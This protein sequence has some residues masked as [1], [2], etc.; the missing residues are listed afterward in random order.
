MADVRRPCVPWNEH[1]PTLSH[2]HTQTYTQTHTQTRCGVPNM[3]F[4]FSTWKRSTWNSICHRLFLF[5]RIHQSED[6]NPC[7]GNA[8]QPEICA[9]RTRNL[10]IGNR[11]GDVGDTQRAHDW[12]FN[13]VIDGCFDIFHLH[14]YVCLQ[15]T[16]QLFSIFKLLH[17]HPLSTLWV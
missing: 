15:P 9:F 5:Y 4:N 10:L 6:V 1:A 3:I 13:F 7:V 8:V 16:P 11:K 14:C 12:Q 2:T 17:V